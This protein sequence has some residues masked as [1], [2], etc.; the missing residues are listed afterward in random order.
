M[1][2]PKGSPEFSIIPPNISTSPYK[3]FRPSKKPVSS[4]GSLDAF[5]G[6]NAQAGPSRIRAQSGFDTPL[7]LPDLF[8][9]KL[10]PFTANQNDAVDIQQ[11]ME[12]VQILKQSKEQLGS[13]TCRIERCNA[14][15][16]NYEILLMHVDKHLQKM[17]AHTYQEDTQDNDD[18]FFLRRRPRYNCPW[19]NCKQVEYDMEQLKRHIEVIHLEPELRCPFKGCNDKLYKPGYG[20]SS[21]SYHSQKHPFPW[22]ESSFQPNCLKSYRPVNPPPPLPDIVLPAYMISHP[23]ILPRG[24]IQPKSKTRTPSPPS[25][26]IPSIPR[27]IYE[28]DEFFIPSTPKLGKTGSNKNLPAFRKMEHP[29]LPNRNDDTIPFFPLCG[30]GISYDSTGTFSGSIFPSTVPPEGDEDRERDSMG[31]FIVPSASEDGAIQLQIKKKLPNRNGKMG[32]GRPRLGVPADVFEWH[33]K[34]KEMRKKNEKLKDRKG[35]VKATEISSSDEKMD[36][37]GLQGTAVIA[38]EKVKELNLNL[39]KCHPDLIRSSALRYS[40]RKTGR[41]VGVDVWKEVIRFENEG[42]YWGEL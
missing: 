25:I 5:D 26:P 29:I 32:L 3:P 30:E 38:E 11:R 12:D 28:E 20:I 7:N 15:L 42:R 40:T 18:N 23:P 10:N 33:R 14:I 16:G 37:D 1:F 4:K 34:Q 36:I 24:Q 41:S 31:N 21:I 8:L 6:S 2:S 35:K 19:G 39:K 27:Y 9:T 17:H 22:E 13:Y